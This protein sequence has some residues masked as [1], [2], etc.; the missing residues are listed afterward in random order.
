MVV[1]TYAPRGLTPILQE[2]LSRDHLA[3]IGAVTAGGRLFLKSYR[4][5]ISSDQVMDFLDHLQRQLRG[6]LLL[7]WDSS[8]THVSK[9]LR[10]YLANGAARRLQVERLPGYAPDLNPTEWVWSYFKLGPLANVACDTVREVQ[11]LV[12]QA[13]RRLQRHPALIQSFIRHVGYQV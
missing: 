1:R 9:K 3:V 8:P 6:R 10:S 12:R 7:V 11:Q 4:Q 13:T 5:A 2:Y